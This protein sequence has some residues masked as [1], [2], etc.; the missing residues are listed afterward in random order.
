MGYCISYSFVN[1]KRYNILILSPL[2]RNYI[3]AFEVFLRK[4]ISC[5]HVR[6]SGIFD[7]KH[8]QCITSF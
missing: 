7:M 2:Y 5:C 3:N 6:T 4:R 8:T 1:L